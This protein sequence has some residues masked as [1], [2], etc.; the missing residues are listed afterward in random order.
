MQSFAT[1]RRFTTP[2]PVVLLSPRRKKQRCPSGTIALQ[3]NSS[4]GEEVCPPTSTVCAKIGTIEECPVVDGEQGTL[5]D[6]EVRDPNDITSEWTLVCRYSS[7]E[8]N[9]ADF[10]QSASVDDTSV[11][12]TLRQTCFQPTSDQCPVDPNT[13][14]RMPFC[15]TYISETSEGA[16][17]RANVARIQDTFDEDIAEYCRQHNTPDCACVTRSSQTLYNALK[18]GLFA[19]ED[20]CWWKSCTDDTTYLIPTQVQNPPRDQCV[21]VKKDVASKI[22]RSPEAYECCAVQEN[23]VYAPNGVE[24]LPLRCYLRD[25]VLS[26]ETWFE[27]FGW[28][29]LLFIFV[30]VIALIAVIVIGI[31]KYYDYKDYRIGKI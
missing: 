31:Q 28:I 19:S 18:P 26:Q 2:S 27:Q 21:T 15:S 29:I 14:E 1:Q 5:V 6:I 7:P 13:G 22:N 4:L 12:E 24:E 25:V 10:V 17:C 16:T 30:L 8:N 23:V 20:G 9:L 3:N 11:P